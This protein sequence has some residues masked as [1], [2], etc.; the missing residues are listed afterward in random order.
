MQKQFYK[1]KILVFASIG[2]VA[3]GLE[4]F[5]G[6][7]NSGFVDNVCAQRGAVTA[8]VL[9]LIGWLRFYSPNEPISKRA[10]KKLAEKVAPAAQ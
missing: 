9:A 10:A 7:L 2:S 6:F 4:A 8:G 3:S 1:S 5:N